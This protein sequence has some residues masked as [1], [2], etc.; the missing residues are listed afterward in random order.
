MTDEE[1]EVYRALRQWAPQIDRIRGGKVHTAKNTYTLGNV[2]IT[3][4][5]WNM[6]DAGKRHT[7]RNW[8]VFGK[9]YYNSRPSYPGEEDE[10]SSDEETEGMEAVS[11]NGADESK[12]ET[13]DAEDKEGKEEEEAELLTSPVVPERTSY[14]RSQRRVK[15]VDYSSIP[16]QF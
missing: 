16:S 15:K 3:L 9:K 10:E 2:I 8:A 7:D 4:A 13:G 1:L 5:A 12:E 6:N 14:R 11:E